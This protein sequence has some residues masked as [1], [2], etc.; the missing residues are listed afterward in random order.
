MNAIE[1][2]DEDL[3]WFEITQ[4]VRDLRVRMALSQT[5]FAERFGLSLTALK[6]W[7][8]GRRVPDRAAL[9]LLRLILTDP[10]GVERIYLRAKNSQRLAPA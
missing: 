5:E 4:D 9:T 3:D 7:E 8:I 2:R 10:T 1:T 6:Q